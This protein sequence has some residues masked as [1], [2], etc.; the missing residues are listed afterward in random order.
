MR[1]AIVVILLLTA[2]PAAA[3]KVRHTFESSV[4]RGKVRRVVVDIP[5]GDVEVRNGAA[6]RLA[7][8]GWVA[9][10]PDSDRNRAKEQRIVDD[11]SVEIYASNDEAIVRRKFGPEASSWRGSMFSDYKIRLEVPAGMSVDLLTRFGDVSIDGSFG[12]IDVDLR[13]GDIDL[14]MPKKDVRELNASARV[15]EV[16]ARLGDEIVEREGVFPGTT[17]YRNENGR[18]IVNVHATAG[19]VRV[20]LTK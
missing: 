7:V 5:T 13:A 16:R 3:E 9:R 1:R 10:D 12:D 15:G 18:S 2:L 11:T 4:P 19:D 14:T 17:R 6:D 8:S 20:N